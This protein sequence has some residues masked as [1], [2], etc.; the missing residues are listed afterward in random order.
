MTD[1]NRRRGHQGNKYDPD[2]DSQ[3][4]RERDEHRR[5]QGSEGK[6]NQEGYGSRDFGN[7]YG[8]SGGYGNS[9]DMNWGRSVRGS[10]S[11]RGNWSGSNEGNWDSERMSNQGWGGSQGNWNRD[12][13]RENWEGSSGQGFAS[14]GGWGSGSERYSGRGSDMYGTQSGWGSG[15]YRGSGSPGF[16]GYAG[17]GSH[18]YGSQSGWGKGSSGLGSSG[19]GGGAGS[20]GGYGSGREFGYS[21]K[22]QTGFGSPGGMSQNQDR[23]FWDRTKDE[24]SSWFGDDEAERRREYDR[25][26]NEMEERQPTNYGYGA[27]GSSNY[28][29]TMNRPTHR[30]K[31]PKDYRRSDDRIREDVSDRLADDEM[32]DA[33]EIAVLVN[34]SEVTL[35]GIVDSREA[36]RRAED[37][38][39]QVSGVQNVQNNIRVNREGAASSRSETSGSNSPLFGFATEGGSAAGGRTELTGAQGGGDSGSGSSTGQ[40][41]GRPSS[42][43]TG[44]DK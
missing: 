43:T 44:K 11:D 35:T 10:G 12:Q 27:I 30:G 5:Q 23:G 33:S 24:V 40:S 42:G 13:D 18:L 32:V 9:S 41:S 15:Q 16:G 20:M 26:M 28:G 37:L 25:R 34:N 17:G 14:Q 29:S 21:S 3:R 1:N 22:Q 8:S 19:W 36:K 6:Y 7:N 4:Q 31:G 2:Y 38:A 39:E